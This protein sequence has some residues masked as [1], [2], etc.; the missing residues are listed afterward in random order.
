MNFQLP[1]QF[2]KLEPSI[3]YHDA[4]YLCGSCFSAN[5]VNYFQRHKFNVEFNSHGIMFNPMS[6]CNSLIEVIEGKQYTEKD[7]FYLNEYWNS[8]NHHSDFSFLEKETC[9][10]TINAAIR[11]HQAFL[12]ESK[13][14][15]ITLGSA[16][17]YW[18]LEEQ[19]YVSN[20]HRAPANV[21]RKD[22]L[23][24]ATIQEQLENLNKALLLFNPNLTIIYTISP[25]RHV[26]DGV[27]E[28]NRSKARLIEA[29]HSLKAIYYFPSYELVVD[30]LRD[31]R[32]YDADLVHPNYMATQVVW[33]QLVQSCVHPSLYDLMKQLEQIYKAK[34]HRP[35]DIRS[36]AHQRFLQQHLALCSELKMLHPEL[37]LEDEMVYF[38]QG[39]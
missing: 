6:V 9:L 16:F 5:M 37:N 24:I 17:A 28:N 25:V 8:W 3:T 2:P 29:V 18:H 23:P 27:I 31:Y 21:F 33:E 30:V 34:Q 1:L 12:K 19:Q 38:S 15:F 35:K 7:L 39:G 22:L 13:F 11:K 20:N 4:V 26:R 32:F 10:T 36:E 14:I